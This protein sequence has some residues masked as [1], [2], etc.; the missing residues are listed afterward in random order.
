MAKLARL[1]QIT[2]LGYDW[3]KEQV[4]ETLAINYFELYREKKLEDRDHYHVYHL[5]FLLPLFLTEGMILQVF[6][7]HGDNRLLFWKEVIL[8]LLAVS[9]ISFLALFFQYKNDG[10]FN[11]FTRLYFHAVVK[12]YDGWFVLL[13]FLFMAGALFYSSF[14][15]DRILALLFFLLGVLV[16]GIC[17]AFFRFIEWGYIKY[18]RPYDRLL[19][20]NSQVENESFRKVLEGLYGTRKEFR[21]THELYRELKPLRPIESSVELWKNYGE[22]GKQNVW[23]MFTFNYFAFWNLFPRFLTV[24]EKEKLQI[25]ILF[26]LVYFLLWIAKWVIREGPGE[27]VTS[28]LV[29]LAAGSS[30][31]LFKPYYEL[32]IVH[33][34]AILFSFIAVYLILRSRLTA[35]LI[36]AYKKKKEAKK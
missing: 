22:E 27:I 30:G 17:F 10:G 32:P 5:F 2:D 4:G 23:L 7:S 21:Y 35:M 36:E 1:N 9:T 19:W 14:L 24:S 31:Q 33:Y 11:V 28:F 18:S 25:Y 20:L 12:D 6:V 16:L 34:F 26:V 13:F 8:F 15:A 3:L 29:L